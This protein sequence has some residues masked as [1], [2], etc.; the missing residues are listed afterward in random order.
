[1]DE[2]TNEVKTALAT[3]ILVGRVVAPDDPPALGE[4]DIDDIDPGRVGDWRF[5][6]H[7]DCLRGWWFGWTRWTDPAGPGL[8]ELW[9]G[10]HKFAR[11][12]EPKDL[13]HHGRPG[14]AE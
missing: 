5:G 14:K 4:T 10:V 3:S 13:T 1:M 9:A 2:N 12:T 8:F 6:Y 11:V 7:G